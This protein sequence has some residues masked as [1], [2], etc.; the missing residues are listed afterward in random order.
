MIFNQFIKKKKKK[1]KLQPQSSKH[2]TWTIQGNKQILFSFI[3]IYIFFYNRYRNSDLV[4]HF[5]TNKWNWL[6]KK[7]KKKPINNEYPLEEK[8]KT[9]KESKDSYEQHNKLRGHAHTISQKYKTIQGNE[10]I[11][12]VFHGNRVTI[13][14]S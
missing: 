7:Q 10:R 11:V 13:L 5:E 2:E 14:L 6:K 9:N 12:D 3:Y 8:R 4:D 1:K